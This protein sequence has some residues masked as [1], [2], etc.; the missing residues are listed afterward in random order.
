MAF[1][2]RIIPHLPSR[3]TVLRAVFLLVLLPLGGGGAV[4]LHRTAGP[5]AVG[6]ADFALS[7]TLALFGGGLWASRRVRRR[8]RRTRR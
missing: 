6:V 1:R 3:Q 5:N 2:K 4:A 8:L 7:L